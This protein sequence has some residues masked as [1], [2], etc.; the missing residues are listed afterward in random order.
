[1]FAQEEISSDVDELFNDAN[2]YFNFEDYNEAL[3]LYLQLYSKIE[4]TAHIDYKIG[5]CYLQIPGEK[6]K[7]I[8]Y[9]ESANKNMTRFFNQYSLTEKKAPYEALFY[10]G[11]AYLVNNQL[12]KSNE[13]FTQFEK[14]INKRKYDII[15][16]DKQKN[17]CKVSAEIQKNP[18]D[19]LQSNIGKKINNRFANLNPI[20]SGN[21]NTMAFTSKLKFYDAIMVSKKDENGQWKTPI[22]ITLQ[23]KTDEPVLTLS[24]S[25]DGTEMYLYR[26]DELDG[27][28][29]ITQYKNGTWSA[30][31]PLNDNINTIYW[32]GHAT[33]SADGSQLY[34]SSNRPG[35][36]GDLDLYISNR[37][38]DGSWGPAKNLGNKI[39]TPFHETAPFL[40]ND[41]S[42]L[43][44]SSQGHDN[45]GGYDIF[46][47]V[48][49]RNKWSRPENMGYPINTTDDELHYSPVKTGEFG[50]LSK[51]DNSSYGL[52]DI[53]MLE[54]FSAKFLKS[55]LA[56]K[57]MERE[58]EFES[59]TNKDKNTITI[60]TIN[61]N[62]Y[63]IL[64]PSQD[65]DLF[66]TITGNMHDY[67]IYFSG[68]RYQFIP[69]T[70]RK[71]EPELITDKLVDDSLN[72]IQ[73]QII[74]DSILLAEKQK[75]D[76]IALDKSILLASSL[77][78]D[79]VS[80]INQN[81]H[82]FAENRV[83]LTEESEQKL[84]Q[85]ADRIR[86]INMSNDEVNSFY[87]WMLIFNNDTNYIH[88]LSDVHS[89]LAKSST[90]YSIMDSLIVHL[91]KAK[92][93]VN[94]EDEALQNILLSFLKLNPEEQKDILELFTNIQVLKDA[95]LV[96]KT[97]LSEE[98]I[99]PEHDKFPTKSKLWVYLLSILAISGGA[100]FIFI[101]SRKSKK[102][103]D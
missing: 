66:K 79:S 84:P 26:D 11:N 77:Q 97:N 12:K 8:K 13:A 49:E 7:S 22:N 20:I 86:D 36:Y 47:S 69:D 85:R 9:L 34:F 56:Q 28:I 65:S 35:G 73:T 23:L 89:K 90:Y 59:T 64:Q 67:Q 51:F 44:F 82:D 93:N 6:Q 41:Q 60:D 43:F 95:Q 80:E 50:L 3:Y 39:N 87:Q 24:L 30:I 74:A 27:N 4:P 42:V 88:Y 54:I 62:N 55:V 40:S 68:N 99:K 76:S 31:Q 101:K 92:Y 37:L 25:N 96:D 72:K 78:K 91:N 1:L 38:P 32:E 58:K 52:Q 102:S 48:K 19:Y 75:S 17:T 21:G 14:L 45:V 61:R 18:V 100:W 10:L 46:Y 70:F 83:L 71:A 2:T 94:F 16:L 103:D 15:Y 33:I 81:Q 29:Y 53:F 5:V 57:K 98:F 63:A